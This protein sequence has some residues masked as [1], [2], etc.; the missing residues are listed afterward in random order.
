MT[1][2]DT[3]VNARTA[4]LAVTAKVTTISIKFISISANVPNSTNFSS[5]STMYSIDIT[6]VVLHDYFDRNDLYTNCQSV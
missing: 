4:T 5:G 2:M 6:N 1:S 3:H